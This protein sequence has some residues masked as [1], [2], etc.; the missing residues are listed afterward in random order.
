MV[1]VSLEVDSAFLEL[2]IAASLCKGRTCVVKGYEADVVG[3]VHCEGDGSVVV[4]C[5]KSN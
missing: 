2:A 1:V 5:G 3:S 4:V